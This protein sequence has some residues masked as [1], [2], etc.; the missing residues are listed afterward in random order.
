MRRSINGRVEPNSFG[1]LLHFR[2]LRISSR[3]PSLGTIFP[4][5][6]AAMCTCISMAGVSAHAQAFDATNLREPADLRAKWFVQAGDDPAY[7][8]PDFDDSH[9]TLFDPSTSITKLFPQRKPDVIWYR[10][11]VK[12]DPS[13][14]GLALK[15][16]NLAR[17]FEIYVNGEKL[18]ASGRIS[19]FA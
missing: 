8:R 5:A 15:E 11:R 9:W 16:Y 18:I 4:V 6:F 17:A 12:V 2:T 10:L 13:Q 7:A 1:G 3:L 14:T 19:P